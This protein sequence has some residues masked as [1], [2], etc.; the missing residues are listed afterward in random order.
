MRALGAL[1]LLSGAAAR[2]G[3]GPADPGWPRCEARQTVDL[4]VVLRD[5]RIPSWALA[6]ILR[7]CEAA[8]AQCALGSLVLRP[9]AEDASTWVLEWVCAERAADG[10]P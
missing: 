3:Q 6:T 4:R 9:S 8:R 10:Q 1:L 2:L 7:R 5:G